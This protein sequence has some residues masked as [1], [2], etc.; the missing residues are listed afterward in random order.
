MLSY[1]VIMFLAAALLLGFGVAI[2]RGRTDLI[3]QYH[4]TKVRDRAAYGRAFGKAMLVC[5]LAPLLSGIIGLFADSKPIG[6]S[7]VAVLLFG[8]IIGIARIV[9]VQRK[10][11][12]GVF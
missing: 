11:N 1:S 8:L 10:Y 7:S 9:S 12:N 3:H 5:A 6:M 2:Y 4:Q